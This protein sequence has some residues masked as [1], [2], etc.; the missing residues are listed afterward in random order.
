MDNSSQ[1]TDLQLLLDAMKNL[2]NGS[3][4]DV[5]RDT[6]ADPTVGDAYNEML[7]SIMIRN[8]QFLARINDAMFR[9]SDLSCVKNI[10]TEVEQQEES[11]K[12]LDN[13]QSDLKYSLSRIKDS[14][15]EAIALSKQLRST[16]RNS[17]G[18]FVINA[19]LR[20][21]MLQIIS[22]VTDIYEQI[23]KQTEI[24]G[25]YIESAN[26]LTKGFNHISTNAFGTGKHLFHIS[27][28]VDTA[29]NDFYRQNSRPTT[30]DMLRVFEVD[31]QTLS[32]RIYNHLKEFE[33]LQLRQIN[34]P[35]GCKFGL[36]VKAQSDPRI[37]DSKEFKAIIDTHNN[38]HSH[39]VACFMANE[40]F[41]KLLAF[42][43]FDLVLESMEKFRSA[44]ANM[45]THLN[46]IGI[47]EETVVWKY[48]GF[49]G[50][51]K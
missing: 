2:V 49:K 25:I 9:I 42:Q 50:V 46:N 38:L 1:S 37:T 16:Y 33:T 26:H 4:Q 30:H 20:Q 31:H 35:T 7:A 12:I 51:G 5:D 34:N 3:F 48:T 10:I 36:W 28:D 8:N 32:W 18:N 14:A 47:E 43:E 23:E 19:G 29:R 11:I 22:D 6:F 44:L 39:A 21:R 13:A 40:A 27:R 24:S 17:D 45:H 41:N 15:L